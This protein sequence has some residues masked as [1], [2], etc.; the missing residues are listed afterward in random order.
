MGTV[1][2]KWSWSGGLYYRLMGLGFDPATAKFTSRHIR[3]DF[4]PFA[5]EWKERVKAGED[6]LVVFDFIFYGVGADDA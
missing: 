1:A 4:L 6:P 2:P 5:D 3:R